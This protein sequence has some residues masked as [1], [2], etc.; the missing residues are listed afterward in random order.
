[1]VVYDRGGVEKEL[2]LAE[3]MEINRET[4]ESSKIDKIKM[5]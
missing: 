1:M 2:G 5:I 4:R 3:K